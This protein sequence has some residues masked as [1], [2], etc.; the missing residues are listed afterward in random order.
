MRR[1]QLYLENSEWDEAGK[2][3]DKILDM[4]VE[5]VD[6][7]VG[8]LCAEYRVT[9]RKQLDNCKDSRMEERTSYRNAIR[10]ASPGVKKE[11]QAYAASARKHAEYSDAMVE[12][13]RAKEEAD[14]RKVSDMFTRLGNFLDSPKRSADCATKANELLIQ[15]RNQEAERK[16]AAQELLEK[17]YQAAC[18]S[19]DDAI[20]AS[21][22]RKAYQMLAELGNYKD[23]ALMAQTAKAT[24]DRMRLDEQVRIAQ[25]SKE[26]EERRKA[27][28]SKTLREKRK[29][30]YLTLIIIIGAVLL[31]I[32]GSKVYN[33]IQ[34]Y[35]S[36]HTYYDMGVTAMESG[37]YSEAIR[38]FNRLT[39]YS[40]I[41]GMEKAQELLIQ[42]V[43]AEAKEDLLNDDL[44]GAKTILSQY[45][46]GDY[47]EIN[48][49]YYSTAEELMALEKYSTARAVY[50]YLSDYLDCEDR[51]VEADYMLADQQFKERNFQTAYNSFCRL[52]GY[53]DA[54]NRA[55]ESVYQYAISLC[56]KLISDRNVAISI[57]TELGDYKDCANYLIYCEAR[58]L[59]EDDLFTAE[60][61][62][63]QLPNDML[64]VKLLLDYIDTYKKWN[65]I[66]RCSNYSG[67]VV[68][69]DGTGEPWYA[70][71]QEYY[72]AKLVLT[73]GYVYAEETCKLDF[74]LQVWNNRNASGEKR[75][76]YVHGDDVDASLLD[77]PKFS[78]Y[79]IYP[80]GD[81]FGVAI[82]DDQLWLNLYKPATNTYVESYVFES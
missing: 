68:Y 22:M 69:P 9:N 13:G 58:D 48:A 75:H 2:T 74:E 37:D 54:D 3:Y 63:R 31:L 15:K 72:S 43:F 36:A 12:L 42:C 81:W 18:K 21:D 23:A 8:K 73:Y 5:N 57:F 66:Y 49:F 79:Y 32:I 50:G 7:H 45:P 78:Y 17:Q 76:T 65:S 28:R 33:Y 67:Q 30:R 1:A 26:A 51:Y 80:S 71:T 64:D 25:E 55:T 14:F 29:K 20:T 62:L 24:A 77:E 70:A 38:N 10:F 40:H 46:T 44:S 47:E 35:Q 27:A 11:L 56:T 34:D 60:T 16:R 6:A 41:A 19:R 52:S 82:I 39:Y 59:A 61:L 4:D 53:R